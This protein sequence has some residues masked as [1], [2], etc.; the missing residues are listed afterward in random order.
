MLYTF[1]TLQS[2]HSVTVVLTSNFPPFA[3]RLNVSE[4]FKHSS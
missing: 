3:G 4:H 2:S 1:T